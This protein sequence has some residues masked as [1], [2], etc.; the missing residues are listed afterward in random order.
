VSIPKKIW[1][2]WYQGWNDAPEIVKKCLQTWKKSN[3]AWT[4]HPLDKNSISEF[5]DLGQIIPNLQDNNIPL[6]ALSDIIRI[7]LLNKYGGIWV[8]STLYCNRPLEHWLDELTSHGFF[9]FSDPGPNRLV[10][11]WFLVSS[12]SNYIV[13]KWEQE[14]TRYW[15][16][17]DERHHYFW[18]HYLFGNLYRDN[19]KFRHMWDLIPKISADKPHYFIPYEHK[20]H[21]Q[22]T[23]EDKGVIEN[24][25]VPVFKLTHKIEKEITNRETVIEYLLSRI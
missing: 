6:E 12:Q 4:I 22:I 23:L 9:A 8:D 2:F 7:S 24:E 16:T 18:F 10:S 1:I 11:S 5:I 19:K 3:P 25:G 21:R 17:R 15:M 14:T 20:L 13:E